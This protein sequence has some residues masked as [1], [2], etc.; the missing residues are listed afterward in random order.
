[1]A[2]RPR[3][4]RAARPLPVAR[5][6]DDQPRDVLHL[7][8]PVRTFFYQALVLQGVLGYTALGAG[9]VGL[10][11]GIML[12]APLDPDRDAGRADRVAA[13]SWSPGRC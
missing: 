3:P 10:P 8:R 6:R 9:L 2:R 4:A 12:A 7:R 13:G 1:M 11:V 5:V